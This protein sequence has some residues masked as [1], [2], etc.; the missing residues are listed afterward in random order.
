MRVLVIEDYEPLR[1]SLL[2]GLRESGYAVDGA[3]NGE[4]GLDYAESTTYDII[5]LDL[6]LPKIDGFGVLERLR[7]RQGESR[8]LILT[9]K[10]KV[11][12]RVRALDMGADDYL[13][14]PFA[15]E[16]FMARMRALQRRKY[17]Q[18]SPT[19]RVAD[20]EID[21]SARVVRLFGQHLDLTAREY[22]I[23]EVLAVRKG[24]MVTRDEIWERIYDFG[25]ERNSN[26]VDVYVGYIRKKL[27]RNGASHL[28]RTK[29]GF[30]YVLGEDT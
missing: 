20:L 3:G 17:R 14:K 27:Q 26:V 11:E 6:M 1:R 12:D 15:Y 21:T 2:R 16:E 5:V 28:I 8:V 10:D 30:G 7:N 24:Q 4:E 13:V 9:A 25:A 22:S 18:T 19:I 29:R 23:L